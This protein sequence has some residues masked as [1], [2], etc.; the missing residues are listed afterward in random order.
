MRRTYSQP[1]HERINAREHPGTRQLC[2]IC[3]EPTGRCE[4]DV[5]YVAD[6]GPLCEDCQDSCYPQ[7]RND[8][9]ARKEMDG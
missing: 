9:L 7:T 6:I 3:D 8:T 5:I 1:E 4:D 2:V